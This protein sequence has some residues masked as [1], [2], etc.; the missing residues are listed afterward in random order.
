MN[1]KIKKLK[2][3]IEKIAN[4][5]EFASSCENGTIEYAVENGKCYGVGLLSKK[6][7]SVQETFMSKGSV[8][9]QHNHDVHEWLLVFEG[10]LKVEYCNGKT[11]EVT[12]GA[13]VHFL[14]GTLH[15]IIALEDTRMIGIVIP[16]TGGYP[17]AGDKQ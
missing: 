17:D 7:V 11:E 14:I 6:E 15:K 2:L 5:S 3:A 13:A 4:L 8:F 12:V 9:P 10:K 1:D 16:T